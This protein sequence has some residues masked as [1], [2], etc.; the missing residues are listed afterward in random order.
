MTVRFRTSFARDLKT[1]KDKGILHR[2][3]QAITK[4]EA[5]TSLQEITGL[6]KLSGSRHYYRIGLAVVGDVVE[7]LRCLHRRDIYRYFP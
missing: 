3:Q 4:V 6:T 5:T 7:F 1:I 2:V